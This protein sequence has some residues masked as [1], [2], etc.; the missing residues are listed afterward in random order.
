[1]R[2]RSAD[3]DHGNCGRRTAAGQGVNCR[4]AQAR[5]GATSCQP[6]Q[7]ILQATHKITARPT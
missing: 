7:I 2:E 6:S 3:S 4:A 5:C 1:V